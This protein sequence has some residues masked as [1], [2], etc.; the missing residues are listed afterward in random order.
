[1]TCRVKYSIR[2]L[3]LVLSAVALAASIAY[4][5]R[6]HPVAVDLAEVTRGPLQVTVDEDG[7]TRIKERYIVS[8]PLAGRLL[9]IE[10]DPGD[11]VEAGVS[12]L[13]IIE[14]GD[15][16]LLD[17]RQRAESAARVKAAETA[18]Q[19][20]APALE[21]ARAGLEF[22][23]SELGRVRQ[24]ARRSVAAQQELDTAE[25]QFR[26]RTEEFRAAAFAQEIAGYELQLARAALLRTQ[27]GA[28]P[29]GEDWQFEIRAPISGRVLRVLQKSSAIVA[30]GAP[31]LELGNPRDLEVEVDVLSTDAVKIPPGAPVLIDHWGGE[32]PLRGTVRLIEPAAFTKVSA[33]GVEEQRVNVIVDFV[34]PFESRASLGD[35]FRVEARVVI[36]QHPDVLRVPAGA[37][38]RDQ[39]TWSVFV[40][41][42]QRARRQP[43]AIGHRNSVSAEVREGLSPGQQVVVH[44]S[45]KVRDGVRLAPRELP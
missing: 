10:L 33:L 9:R 22:A 41:Q 36:W 20:A 16:E 1:V 15:P 12:L 38:F 26:L 2:K 42:Q 8:A 30:A 5:F 29:A 40:A 25:L 21:Q 39:D 13:A 45:D 14:P 7:R 17:A 11:A 24:L 27:G 34:D 43:I 19:R 18:V 31:L 28:E 37:L 23:E 3:L 32:Q 35:G 4:A 6:P 44:P